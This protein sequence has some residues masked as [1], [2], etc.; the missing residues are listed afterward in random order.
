MPVKFPMNAGK[1]PVRQ[2]WAKFLWKHKM[3][4]RTTSI[5]LVYINILENE[6]Q[7]VC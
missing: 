7:S 3:P 6:M 2:F 1:G 4:Y 5:M